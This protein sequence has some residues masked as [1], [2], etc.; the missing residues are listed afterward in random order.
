MRL[1]AFGVV[2]MRSTFIKVA[3]ENSPRKA[4]MHLSG[5]LAPAKRLQKT[6]PRHSEQ[7]LDFSMTA[8]LVALSRTYVKGYNH[9]DIVRV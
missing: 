6:F 1:L 4:R 8:C 2:G 5:S 7:I 3:V 9:Q